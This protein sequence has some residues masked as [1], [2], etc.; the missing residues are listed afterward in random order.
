MSG[1]NLIRHCVFTLFDRK[2][3]LN[4]DADDVKFEVCLYS[5]NGLRHDLIDDWL[6]DEILTIR[7]P[8]RVSSINCHG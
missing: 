4:D 2:Y 6:H 3:L 7:L 8:E 5:V 1:S